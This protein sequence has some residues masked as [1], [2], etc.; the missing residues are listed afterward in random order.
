M[1]TKLS[2]SKRGDDAYGQDTGD[3]ADGRTDAEQQHGHAEPEFPAETA[4]RRRQ[5]SAMTLREA[6][7]SVGVGGSVMIERTCASVRA[8]AI[9]PE[10]TTSQRG[11]NQRRQPRCS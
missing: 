10:Y 11:Q 2:P 4:A 1:G 9:V 7:T 3:E 8:S 5:R 6:A